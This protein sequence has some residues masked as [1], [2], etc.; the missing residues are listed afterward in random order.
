MS[1]EEALARKST[2]TLLNGAHVFPP[3]YAC[4]LLRSRATPKS[5]RTYVGSTPNPPRRIRQHN[6]ELT[7]GAVKTSRFRPWVSRL[8]STLT[9]RQEMQMIVYGYDSHLS[10]S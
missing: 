10:Q 6:G 5:N 9:D 4:Y 1:S 3:F 7:Q 8:R 2:S